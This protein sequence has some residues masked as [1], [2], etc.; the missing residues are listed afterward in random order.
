M[1]NRIEG[2]YRMSNKH[3]QDNYMER[4]TTTPNT[5]GSK[6]KKINDKTFSEDVVE[7]YKGHNLNE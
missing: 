7:L 2:V 3:P 5:S 4:N 6:K 1:I